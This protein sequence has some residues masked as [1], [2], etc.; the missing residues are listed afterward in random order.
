MARTPEEVFDHH[1]HALVARDIDELVSDYADDSVLITP[2]GATR[3]KDGIRAAFTK[4][5]DGL[6][7]AAFDVKTR[8]FDGDVL[9]LEWVLDSPAARVDGVDTFVFGDGMI[10]VQTVSQLAHPKA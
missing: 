1:I 6:S 9:L 8:T 10:R 5:A 3:G 7:D 2:D 4:L